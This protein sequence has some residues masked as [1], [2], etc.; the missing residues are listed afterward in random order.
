MTLSLRG[1][2]A[3]EVDAGI[4]PLIEALWERGIETVASCEDGGTSAEGGLPVGLAWVGF[5]DSSH[6][7]R[8]CELA[9]GVLGGAF[10]LDAG[11]RAR[12]EQAGIPAGTWL[13]TFPTAQIEHLAGLVR[14]GDAHA[15]PSPSRFE[16]ARIG[17]N[18][19]CWCGSGE[20]SKRCHGR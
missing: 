15:E 19:P 1:E 18:E 3:V 12:A 5:P 9:R 8:F 20:K 11:V 13:V 14:D 6:A 7:G 17:R 10:P 4:A 16:R 2:H